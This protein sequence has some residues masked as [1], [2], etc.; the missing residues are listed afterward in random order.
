MK[1][2]IFQIDNVAEGDMIQVFNAPTGLEAKNILAIIN[3]TTGKPV[4]SPIANAIASVSYGQVTTDRMFIPLKPGHPSIAGDLL[5]KAYS[6]DAAGG[7]DEMLAE[8]FGL[9]EALPEEYQPMAEQDVTDTME[10][11]MGTLDIDLNETVEYP[12]G[13]GVYM[14]RAQAITAQ[15]NEIIHSTNS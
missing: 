10:Y 4:H 14:T 15:T 5:I 6:D 2:Y 1:E 7:Y 13:S 11:I 9:P 3:K 12:E 8:F